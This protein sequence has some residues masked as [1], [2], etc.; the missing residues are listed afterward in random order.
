MRFDSL[1]KRPG[2]LIELGQMAKMVD[3][4]Q[5]K[6]PTPPLARMMVAKV[7]DLRPGSSEDSRQKKAIEEVSKEATLEEAQ[8]IAT[9]LVPE[10]LSSRDDEPLAKKKRTGVPVRVRPTLRRIM[11]RA[12]PTENV[13]RKGKSV[14]MV[15]TITVFPLDPKQRHLAVTAAGVTLDEEPVGATRKKRGRWLDFF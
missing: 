2:Y 11:K 9:T 15:E 13:T 7:R 8:N 4:E 5:D 10:E 12:K 3:F 1:L 6:K 14:E